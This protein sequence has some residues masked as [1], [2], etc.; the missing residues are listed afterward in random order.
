NLT[1]EINDANAPVVA[2]V[3]LPASF[4]DENTRT[5]T[6]DKITDV[7]NWLRGDDILNEWPRATLDLPEAQR[8]AAK[9]TRTLYGAPIHSSPV[10]VNYTSTTQSGTGPR[11]PLEPDDQVNLIF[12]STNDG[13]LYAVDAA[14]GNEKLAFVPGA[15]LKRPSDATPSMI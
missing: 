8:Q 1:L 7:V 6:E 5:D 10:V 11:L 12:V 4:P 2:A 9:V 3:M 14:T 13:K 15:F